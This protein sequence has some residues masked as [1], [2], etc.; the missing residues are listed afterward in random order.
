MKIIV[1][2]LARVSSSRMH[3][4]YRDL[5]NYGLDDSGKKKIMYGTDGRAVNYEDTALLNY[6]KKEAWDMLLRE[7]M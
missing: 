3:K 2:C 1:D 6:R 4:K 5:I 7:V